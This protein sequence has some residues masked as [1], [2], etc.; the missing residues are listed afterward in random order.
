MALLAPS[1]IP[2]PL[3]FRSSRKLPVPVILLTV[4][5][6]A[7][8]A[9]FTLL[10]LPLAVPPVVSVK[11]EVFT[12]VTDSEKLTPN[13]TVRAEERRVGRD[14]RTIL[15]TDGGVSSAGETL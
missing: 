13:T 14:E 12:P 5:V 3:A 6:Y 7:A 8:P 10:M 2:V 11:S 15:T 1:T 4:T 9:P